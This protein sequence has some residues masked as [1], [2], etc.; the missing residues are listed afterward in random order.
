MGVAFEALD[1]AR[2]ERVAE[3]ARQSH[4]PK[5]SP[6]LRLGPV[7]N[8]FPVADELDT[9]CGQANSAAIERPVRHNSTPRNGRGALC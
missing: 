7:S 9:I 5:S 2:A 3:D 8:S 4:R 1:E 6:E